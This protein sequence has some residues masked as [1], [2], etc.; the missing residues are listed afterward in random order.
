MAEEGKIRI[1]SEGHGTQIKVFGPDGVEWTKEMLISALKI[2][3]DPHGFCQATMRLRGEIDYSVFPEFVTVLV[4]PEGG[5]KQFL[6]E[7]RRRKEDEAYCPE[8]L[9]R[10][11][12]PT[13]CGECGWRRPKAS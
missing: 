10:M 11:K 2:E 9:A 1:V 8:C 5:E 6:K 12:Q 4:E 3:S 7:A 13:R